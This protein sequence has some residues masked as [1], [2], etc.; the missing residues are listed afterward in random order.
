MYKHILAYKIKITGFGYFWRVFWLSEPSIKGNKFYDAN[1]P[2]TVEAYTELVMKEAHDGGSDY[3][4]K[5]APS[6]AEP[7]E[8]VAAAAPL[9]PQ[10]SIFDVD[11][12]QVLNDLPKLFTDHTPVAVM[13]V[14]IGFLVGLLAALICCFPSPHVILLKP[15]ADD[16]V[17]TD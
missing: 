2:R 7:E 12:V 16:K 11:P 6:K 5:I 14:F 8:Q 1:V 15:K 13:L 10:K 3:P 17:K 4:P 9:I